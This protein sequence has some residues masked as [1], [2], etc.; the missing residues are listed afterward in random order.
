MTTH[1]GWVNHRLNFA[2]QKAALEAVAQVLG[3]GLFVKEKE[4]I[5]PFLYHAKTF[6]L[7]REW[8]AETSTNSIVD[9]TTARR[10]EELSKATTA[11]SEVIMREEVIISL[12]RPTSGKRS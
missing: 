5:F 12:L 6:S 8:L 9:E 1:L 2:L 7:L 10:A 11:D 3:D 4:F